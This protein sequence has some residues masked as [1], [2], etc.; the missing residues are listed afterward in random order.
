MPEQYPSDAELLSMVADAATGAEYVPTG[1]SPYH[2]A[3]RKL[4]HRLCQAAARA[5]DLR[6]YRDGSLTIGIRPGRLHIANQP[7]QFAGV[8]AFAVSA[9]AVTWLWLTNAGALAHSTVALP[10]DRS[11]ILPLAKVTAGAAEITEILDLR[12]E[13]LFAVPSLPTLGVTAT[14]AEV[15]RALSGTASHVDAAAL[16]V[17]TAGPHSTADSEH[18]HV[19]LEQ[20]ANAQ[21]LYTLANISAGENAGVAIRM[22][23]PS[24]PAGDTLLRMHPESGHLTQVRGNITRHMLAATFVAWQHAGELATSLTDQLVGIVPVDGDVIGVTLSVR[25]NLASSVS[26]DSL[27][28]VVKANGT[29]LTTTHPALA[30]VSGTGFRSTAQGHGSAAVVRSDGLERV[31][32][33]DVLTLDLVRTV[34]GTLSVAPADVCVLV[35]I[36]ALS[37]E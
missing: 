29:N 34:T 24:R 14:A 20:D 25:Q 31:Q 26:T 32:R 18:R 33:G 7:R 9:S 19:R 21:A 3:F 6:V 12:S 2:L 13:T 1:M 23:L 17:L 15:S 36:R 11:A 8:E 35:H 37:P 22:S 5:N 10:A 4:V 27:A 16:N 28:A 30:S